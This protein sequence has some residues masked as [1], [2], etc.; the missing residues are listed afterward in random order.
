MSAITI[1]L[2]IEQGTDFSA[3]FNIRNV[4]S[5]PLNLL[6]YSAES[7]LKTSYYTSSSTPFTINFVD[8]AKGVLN[9][10]LPDSTTSTLK[11]RRYV[12]DVVLISP[13]GVKTR[14]IEGI[15]TVTPGVTL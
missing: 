15:A 8:R 12:Y 1:N 10:S 9:I 14:V 2:V 6:G 13:T 4:G 11:P 3:T 7:N 5:A